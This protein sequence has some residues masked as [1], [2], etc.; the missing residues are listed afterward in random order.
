MAYYISPN[1]SSTLS[2]MTPLLA[3]LDSITVAPF[4]PAGH[5]IQWRKNGVGIKQGT[6]SDPSFGT[7]NTGSV[8]DVNFSA[9]DTGS[10]IDFLIDPLSSPQGSQS[11]ILTNNR[12]TLSGAGPVT[13]AFGRTLGRPTIVW[14]Y[15]DADND[16]QFQYQVKIGSAIG[17]GDFYDTG[18]VTSGA[19]TTFSVTVPISTSAIPNGTTYYWKIEVSDGEKV[20]PLDVSPTP[21]RVLTTASGTGVVNTPPVISAIT[22]DGTSGGA[23]IPSKTPSIAWV[24]SDIDTQPQHSF[25]IK[26]A[27]DALFA[28]LIWDSGVIIS[29][30]TSALYNF[31]L[32]G[33]VAPSHQLLYVGVTGNDGLVDSTQ[34]VQ[35]FNISSKP[36][37]TTL[38][39]DR[40]VNPLNLR[41]LLPVFNWSY[42]DTDNDPL[43]AFQIRVST[44]D[45]SLGS[46]SFIGLIWNTGV[47]TT[48]ESYSAQFNFDGSAFPGCPPESSLQ[49]GT[50]YFFQVKIYDAFSSSDWA[51]GYFELNNAPTAANLQI[52]PPAPFN[53]DDL[54]ATYQFIDDVG[55]N[56]GSNTQIKWFRKPV[57]GG[58]SEVVSLQNQKMVPHNL[59]V[60]GDQWK[61]SVRPSDGFE[62]SLLTYTSNP[63][64]ISNRAPTASAL[65]I[66]PSMPRTGDNLKAMFALADPDEDSVSATVRWYKNGIEQI[67]LKNETV[68]PASVTN[69]DEQWYFTVLPTDGYDTGPL[70]TSS[71]VTIQN[72]PP[73]IGAVFVDGA[74]LPN[75]VK[76]PNPVFSWYYQDDDSQAQQKFELLIGTQPV[77]TQKALT[78][79]RSLSSNSAGLGL[80]T[81]CTD[82]DGVISTAKNGTI[83]AGNDI[84]DSG[85]IESSDSSYQYKTTDFMP[86]ITLPGS[87]FQNLSNYQLE[88][89]LTTLGLLVGQENGTA[90]ATF[91]GSSGFYSIELTY[92]KEQTKKSTYKIIIDGV[93]SGQFA[94]APGQGSAVHN[95]NSIRLETGSSVS[96][97]G[98]ASDSGARAK[99]QKIVC[100]PITQLDLNTSDFLTLSGYLKDGSGGIKLAGLMGSA[101]IPFSFPSGTYDVE[102]IYVTETNGN[103]TVSFSINNS[104]ALSF[105]Y[106]SGAQVR[107]K[108]ISGVQINRGDTLKIMGTRNAGALARVKKIVF[109]PTSTSI[110]GA[111]L[112]DGITYFASIR[113]FDGRDWSDWYT[114][115]FTMNGAA[116]SAVSNSTGWTIEFRMNVAPQKPTV[117]VPK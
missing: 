9:Q 73:T 25:R 15:S 43:T 81:L 27:T 20:N 1:S 51:T 34:S 107:S 104:V 39:V 94:S 8:A 29:S 84:F 101:S 56:E 10:Y 31:N 48:P 69:I 41:S 115:K 28:S 57:G 71:I 76:N 60:P 42:I 92:I 54:L 110:I 89:D 3:R 114:T 91:K 5:V 111:K 87:F 66:L 100:N 6:T 35:T 12:P 36:V 2:H 90:S 95:F 22:I 55:D 65:V 86:S 108:F 78:N 75:N 70:G 40:L 113:A 46:D 17:L 13:D 85:V 64:T 26:V 21:A 32:T 38:T 96:I 109:R 37:I 16:P 72:T 7:I 93:V 82:A 11:I 61:F 97:V 98:L 63:V 80:S 112:K 74:T 30:S 67:A 103:P 77:R 44:T 53:N 45:T 49:K 50:K 52:V 102:L 68:V 117:T 59:T 58:F 83:I 99:F 47:V 116:W 24:Y 62:F 88:S 18:V 79:I 23:T 105:V 33:I 4:L 106:E 14:T 19:S